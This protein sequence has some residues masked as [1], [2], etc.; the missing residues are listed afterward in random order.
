VTI[1]IALLWVL[2]AILVFLPNRFCVDFSVEVSGWEFFPYDWC[3]LAALILLS[4]CRWR[5]DQTADPGVYRPNLTWIFLALFVLAALSTLNPVNPQAPIGQG[6]GA[7][8]AIALWTSPIMVLPLLNLRRKEIE[9]ILIAFVGLAAL[10]ALFTVAQSTLTRYIYELL[11]WKYV[12]YETDSERR[13]S[14]PLGVATVVGA[15][16]MM[17]LPAAWAFAAIRSRWFIR[18]AGAAAVIML[19]MG[20]LFTSSRSTVAVESMVLLGCALFL[21]A[22]GT[23]KMIPLAS[24][25]ALVALTFFAMTTLN[26]E[27]LSS[28]RDRSVAWRQRG[29]ETAIAI[30]MERPLFGSGTETYFRRQH[31]T[32]TG[33][34]G[35]S[36][37][38]KA[39]LYNNQLSPME[40]H[41]TYL[42]AAA[43]WGLIGLFLFLALLGKVFFWLNRARKW[44]LEETG[45]IWMKV[46]LIGSGAI[47]VH[48]LTG[49]DLLRQARLAPLFWCY[50]GLGLSYG[51]ILLSERYDTPIL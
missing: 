38:T 47:L 26:F 25:A 33:Y 34:L 17:A 2:F 27:R 13:G 5:A 21:R 23:S 44:S 19:G 12:F 39:V 9:S 1:R 51:R 42:F 45:Q 46:F 43:E 50:A 48:C 16:Y 15:Y 32:V 14:L 31:H 24:I 3:L 4:A 40:P 10:G 41:N 6:M 29:L 20:C 11:G 18:L 37:G 7:L 49:S 22:K 36:K 30:L 35:T 28:L 8:A